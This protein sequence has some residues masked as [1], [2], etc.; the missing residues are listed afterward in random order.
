MFVLPKLLSQLYFKFWIFFRILKINFRFMNISY[1]YPLPKFSNYWILT[2]VV[3]QLCDRLWNFFRR[4]QIL[5][6]LFFIDWPH[7]TPRAKSGPNVPLLEWRGW[8][9]PP[10]HPLHAPTISSQTMAS[11]KEVKEEK[12]DQLIFVF[13]IFYLL[14][15]TPS[16][17]ITLRSHINIIQ[18]GLSWTLK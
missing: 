14:N 1:L 5:N 11:H 18:F 13:G 6:M 10:H 16:K 3:L 12:F 4:R 8:I 7:S 2:S 15:N 17:L 9:F